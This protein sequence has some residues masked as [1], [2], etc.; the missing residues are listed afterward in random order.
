MQTVVGLVCVVLGVMHFLDR[1][2]AHSPSSRGYYFGSYIPR[3][4]AVRTT[5]ALIEVAVGFVLLFT[6]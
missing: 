6:A 2:R 3:S 5:L 4:H 1:D